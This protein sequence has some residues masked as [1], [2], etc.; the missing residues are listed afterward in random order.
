MRKEALQIFIECHLISE[1]KYPP[2]LFLSYKSIYKIHLR[3]KWKT[4]INIFLTT[5]ALLCHITE[6][7]VLF[8]EDKLWENGYSSRTNSSPFPL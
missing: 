8:K 7:T 2:W 6:E 5:S 3:R 4:V 1:T